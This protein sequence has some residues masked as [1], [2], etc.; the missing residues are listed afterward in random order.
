[1]K[2][3]IILMFC[4]TW[5][6]GCT[7]MDPAVSGNYKWDG[8]LVDVGY[9]IANKLENNLAAALP[10]DA[11]LIVASFVNVDD[12]NQSSTF[13]RVL[14]EQI[15]SRF[16]QKGYKV[17]ELKLRQNNIFVEEGKGEFLL[18]RNI[19]NISVN[20]DASAV[21]V[22]TYGCAMD[23]VYVSARMINPNTNTILSSCDFGVPMDY[24]EQSKLIRHQTSKAEQRSGSFSTQ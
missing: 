5:L 22:G 11:Q 16:A 4:I 7:T 10:H 14:S 8:N 17:I 9:T 1:M 21:I 24:R 12:L 19:R 23:R 15:G 6:T 20:H 2:K 3:F 18:S 13:G